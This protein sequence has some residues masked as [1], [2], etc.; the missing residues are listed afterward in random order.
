MDIDITKL[1]RNYRIQPLSSKEI[2]KKED[3][4]ELYINQNLTTRDLMKLFSVSSDRVIYWLKYYN[5]KKS[6]EDINKRISQKLKSEE[7]KQKARL[8]NLQ[9]C[10]YEN[11]AQNPVNTAKSKETRKQRYGDENFNNRV[12]TEQTCQKKYG[13]SHV[14]KVPEIRKK[15]DETCIIKYGNKC[16]AQG[17]EQRKQADSKN[18]KIYGAKNVFASTII[19][20]KIKQ[21]MCTLEAKQRKSQIMSSVEVQVKI[22][23]TKKGKIKRQYIELGLI[24]SQCRYFYDFNFQIDKLK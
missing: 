11:P 14:M 5:I 24:E 8:S 16:S 12:Q 22:N 7:T 9:N 20:E 13:Y 18:E 10:G 1:K 3:L 21:I 6:K 17:E 15:V 2:I 19:K 23:K 4:V